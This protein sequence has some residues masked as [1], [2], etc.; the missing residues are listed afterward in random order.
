MKTQNYQ[1]LTETAL[2]NEQLSSEDCLNILT[3]PDID[4]LSLVHAAY[5]VRKEHWGKDVSIHILNNAQ[6]GACPEDCA[7]CAQAKTSKSDINKYPAKEED[8][9]LAEA[10]RA[11]ENGAFRYCMVY[12]GRGP[13]KKRIEKL[14]GIIRKIKDNYPIEVCLSPGLI[15]AEDAETLKA[16]GLDRFNHNLNTSKTYYD[17]ICTTHTYEDRLNT[18]KSVQKA[19]IGMC[20]GIIVGMG[21]S[22]EDIVEVALK[23]RELKSNSIPVNFYM[24]IPGNTMGQ[25]NPLTPE[26]C[27]RVLC[28]FRFLNPTSELRMAAGRE[29][30]LRNMQSLGLFVAN[31]LFM[32]GY[33]NTKGGNAPDTLAM[34]RDA[35]FTIKA[36]RPVEAII[37]AIEN[38]AK[39]KGPETGTSLSDPS[40]T[41]KSTTD[42]RPTTA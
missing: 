2:S 22:S 20:S 14:S 26:Y 25:K 34:I 13:R 21:E 42:L 9:M 5:A 15:D 27:L 28:L 7:Y 32:D 41:I 16:A 29:M 35:G 39:E 37:N 11:Y 12:S 38:G 4:I 36:D 40:I 23:L 19:G 17:K 33:L 24:P 6:N 18:L 3:N 8:E 1:T 31:S 30:H 10:K